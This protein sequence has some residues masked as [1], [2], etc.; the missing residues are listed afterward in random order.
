MA[1][2]PRRLGASAEAVVSVTGF[3]IC[4]ESVI[5]PSPSTGPAD[6]RGTNTHG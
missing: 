2:Q 6:G 4:E 5:L 3:G 1:R